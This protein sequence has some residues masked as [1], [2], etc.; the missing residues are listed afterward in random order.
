MNFAF[1]Q[2][3][4]IGILNYYGELSSERANELTEA[5]KVSLDNTDNLIVNLQ[6]V[7]FSKCASLIPI[8]LAHNNASKQNKNVKLIGID[9]EAL[10]CAANHLPVDRELGGVRLFHDYTF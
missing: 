5:L 4:Y 2:Y 1:T 10:I 9:K 6:N 7:S 3:G 8:L